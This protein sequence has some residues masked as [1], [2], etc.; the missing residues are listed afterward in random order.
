M[1]NHRIVVPANLTWQEGPATLP[2]GAKKAL[3]NGDPKDAGLFTMRLK[4]PAGYKIMPHR[5]TAD[6]HVTVM[7]G[8]FSMGAGEKFDER[9]MPQMPLGGFALMPAG[10]AHYGYAKAACIIQVHGVGPWTVTYV[11]SRDD[12]RLKK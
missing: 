11:D 5:H 10:T 1:P 12:P 2:A 8:A 6:E 7:E 3:L 4:L 9:T